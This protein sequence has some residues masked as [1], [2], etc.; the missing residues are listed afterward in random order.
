V[1]RHAGADRIIVT[2]RPAGDGAELEVAD[3]GEGFEPSEP[4]RA[5]GDGHFG[6]VGMRE[7]AQRLGGSLEVTSE[8]G[9]GTTIRA[10]VPRDPEVL[11][12]TQAPPPGGSP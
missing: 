1:R 5:R 6:L 9:A 10:I 4:E 3:D 11:D 12:P 8:P 2:L 7:R